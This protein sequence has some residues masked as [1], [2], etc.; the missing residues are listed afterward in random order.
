MNHI[1][2]YRLFFENEDNR[3][4]ISY[5]FDGCLHTSVKGLDPIDFFDWESWV[6]F[7]EMHVKM[8]EDAKT[9][10]IVIVTARPPI[11]N[12]QIWKFV[13]E[14]D[15]PVED[16]IATDNMPKYRVLKAMGAVRHYDDNGKMKDGLKQ[17]GIEFVQTFPLERTS[18]TA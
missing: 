12:E 10:R 9:H 17:L 18:T 4:V 11:S 7:E 8:K 3:P 13:Q 5:D 6:P 15:L 16:V 2:Q 1:K 14:Y